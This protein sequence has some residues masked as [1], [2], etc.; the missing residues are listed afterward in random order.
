MAKVLVSDFF[1]KNGTSLH[2]LFSDVKSWEKYILSLQ[3]YRKIWLFSGFMT[4]FQTL[5]AQQN[6]VSR[7]VNQADGERKI[8][9]MVHLAELIQEASS[10]ESGIEKSLRWLNQKIEEGDSSAS[11]HQLRLE[12]DENLVKIVTVHKAKGLEYPVVFLPFLWSSWS[13]NSEIISFHDPDSLEFF[14]DFGSKLKKHQ[15]LAQKERLA[16]NLRFLYVAFTRARYCCYF[17]WGPV[18]NMENSALSY[19]FQQHFAGQH[20]EAGEKSSLQDLLGKVLNGQ[21][22]LL[23]I[24]ARPDKACQHSR[25]GQTELPQLS[26]KKFQG[27]INTNWQV[28][29]YSQ[30]SRSHGSH[31]E[32][33]SQES[34]AQL[35]PETSNDRFSFP[36]G[37]AAGSCLHLMFEEIDFQQ[38]TPDHTQEIVAKHLSRS[39]FDL[40]WTQP[41]CQWIEE[42]VHTPLNESGELR[43]RNITR[44]NRIDELGF[45]FS[46][47]DVHLDK[48][49]RV[50]NSADVAPL[51]E[52][53][54]GLNGLMKGFIDLVFRVKGKYF[55]ADYKSNY[56]G[57]QLEH[58]GKIHLQDAMCDHH[59]DLQYLIYTVALHRFLQSR[60]EDYDYNSHFGGVYY[61]FLRGMLCQK[62]PQTGVFSTLPEST[63]I[64]EL[65]SCFLEK[66]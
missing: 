11:S 34:P 22:K 52:N 32:T 4:M 29:S 62:G 13:G 12:S 55:I 30:I 54:Q 51:D 2:T 8:T 21:Q 42:I 53:L 37:P 66:I 6:I 31:Q 40:T 47:Q 15:D 23:S 28:T 3:N 46:L 10:H 60:L 49:N 44:K 16:E 27:T 24:A 26:V 38:C 41:V 43:L 48:L 56:L 65:N 36:K 50:L 33:S 17:T 58:Y 59:Y 39:G 1:G 9:N 19:L 5:L 7:L 64:E 14:I 25:V 20:I 61:L 57:P 18:S 35:P 45:Y 63:F